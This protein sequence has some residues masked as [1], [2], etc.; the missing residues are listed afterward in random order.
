MEIELNL[1]RNQPV[2]MSESVS[3]TTDIAPAK[4]RRYNH[5]LVTKKPDL[6]FIYVVTDEHD[7]PIF[8]HM[9][10]RTAVRSSALSTTR[11]PR[12]G[13]F[14]ASK[15]NDPSWK[16]SDHVKLI[17]EC[18]KGVP[19]ARADEL[20]CFF[21]IEYKTIYA[22]IDHKWNGKCNLA[23]HSNITKHEHKFDSIRAE[24][25]NG[26]IDF[27]I[28]CDDVQAAESQQAI[29]GD[30]LEVTTDDD[31]NQVRDVLETYQ[32]ARSN[33]LSIKGVSEVQ[34]K[35]DELVAEYKIK[36]DVTYQNF[37][38]DWNSLGELIKDMALGLSTQVQTHQYE[39]LVA[40]HFS[41]KKYIRIGDPLL[42]T[43]M[44]P[45]ESKT[46]LNNLIQIRGMIKQAESGPKDHTFISKLAWTR[47]TFKLPNGEDQ[48]ID[49]AL[50]RAQ[51]LANE[52]TLTADQCHIVNMRL[53]ELHEEKQKMCDAGGHA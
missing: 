27:D 50:K 6:R 33:V 32:L 17:K 12:L 35:C 29:F 22:E 19:V 2:E 21:I 14:L 53:K 49:K 18:P 51:K 39:M 20:K 36:K 11:T 37:A 52:S 24:F 5:Q 41:I 47:H 23:Y 8:I 38:Q 31:G 7:Q 4:K 15:S 40:A 26:P 30:L 28:E 42:T 43:N 45:L 9:T 10:S 3:P 34:Q 13:K 16:L 46:A 48:G 25:A 1:Q 44:A